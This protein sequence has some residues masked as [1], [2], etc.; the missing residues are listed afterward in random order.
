MKNALPLILTFNAGFV[1]TAGFLA[2]HGLFTVHVTGN[3]VTLGAALVQGSAG[4]LSKLL[5]LPVFCATVLMARLAGQWLAA[6]GRAELRALLFL[7]LLLLAMGAALA[8]GFGPFAH[9]DMPMALATGMVLVA[10]MAIQNAVHRIHLASAPPSTLMTGTTTQIMIELA[11]LVRGASAEA[12]ASVRP[13]I[14]AMG[15]AMLVFA[16]GCA[17]G[18]LLYAQ[19]GGWCFALPPLVALLT[20]PPRLHRAWAG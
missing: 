7:K 4:A 15:T 14:A 2:L 16:G 5:A 3:F 13:R 19:L 9:G 10:A 17:A 11:D 1:D 8:I 6:H 12:R 20:L 18:A